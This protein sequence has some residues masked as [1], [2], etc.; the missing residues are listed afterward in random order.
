[1]QIFCMYYAFSEC[2]LISHNTPQ[3]GLFLTGKGTI[4]KPMYLLFIWFLFA[5]I[6]SIKQNTSQLF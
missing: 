2:V 6:P 1:M 5:S 4:K 3:V